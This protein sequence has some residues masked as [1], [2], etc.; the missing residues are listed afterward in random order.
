M[1]IFDKLSELFYRRPKKLALNSTRAERCHYGDDLAA[2]YCKRTLSFQ[3]IARKWR[4]KRYELDIVCLYA[5]FW[6]SSECVRQQRT[7]WLVANTQSM[8]IKSKFYN[9]AR[10]LTLINCKILRNTPVL[11]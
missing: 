3:V 1:S 6:F 2:A 10:R 8:R 7:R 5:G 11:M 4:H 9:W